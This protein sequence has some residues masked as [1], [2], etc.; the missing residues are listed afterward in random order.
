MRSY[1]DDRGG[2]MADPDRCTLRRT[3]ETYRANFAP[4]VQG[5]TIVMSDSQALRSVPI[6]KGTMMSGRMKLPAGSIEETPRR[7]NPE[8]V[9]GR[10]A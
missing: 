4:Y 8:A 3:Q 2:C 10:P 5:R 9:T 1:S 6:A 7:Q